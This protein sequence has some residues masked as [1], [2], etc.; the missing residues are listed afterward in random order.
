VRCPICGALPTAKCTLS[1]G[2]PSLKTHSARELAATKAPASGHSGFAPL[3]MLRAVTTG[4]I[5]VL[6]S[7]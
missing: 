2:H 1:T 3:R 7:K 6:F 5:R 4:G